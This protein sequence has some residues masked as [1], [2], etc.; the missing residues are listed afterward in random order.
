M[1]L[2]KAEQ[3]ELDALNKELGPPKTK[4]T[5]VGGLTP[6]EQAE[7]DALNKEL[8]PPKHQ[9]K[10]LDTELPFSTS[11]RGLIKSGASALPIAGAMLGGVVGT[12]LGPLGTVGGAGLGA[13]G[14]KSLQTTIEQGLLGEKKTR[15]QVYLDPLKEGAYGAAGEG[16]GQALGAG[17]KMVGQ[18]KPAKYA[19]KKVGDA[20]ARTGEA[21]TGISKKEI[22]T[23]A[24]NA[25]EIVDLYKSNDGDVQEAADAM[26][27]GWQE[28]IQ[29]TRKG[30]N[31]QISQALEKRVDEF[32]DVTDVVDELEKAKA[33]MN[34]KLRSGEIA[35]VD[36][37]IS[38]IQE[39]SG[40]GEALEVSLKDA[41]DLKEYLQEIAK[42]SYQKGGQIFQ[43]GD[44]A[45]KAAK[46]GAAMARKAVNKAAPEIAKANNAL[47]NLHNIE[48]KVNK[49]ILA[50]GKTV[51]PV[52]AIGSG[53]NQQNIKMARMLDEATGAGIISDSEKLAAMR[54]FGSPQILPVDTTGKSV[55]RMAMGTLLGSQV[56]GPIG[57][58]MGG[59]LSSPLTLKYGIQGGRAIGDIGKG[60]LVDNPQLIGQ[61]LMQN[62]KRKI[63][64][65]LMNE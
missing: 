52:M 23:F 51:A 8:G 53:A 29:N 20:L 24:K 2:S 1:P 35:E 41:H 57:A 32:V 38:K 4:M 27:R 11:P 21:L 43:T 50:E 37:L 45:Q 16:A 59:A 17:L 30:L 42:G 31:S 55:G 64:R 56:G 12:A 7:L 44:K 22:K 60:I 36:D 65:G 54:T 25:D 14:G 48:N 19:A 62:E 5:K 15:K 58:A 3:A 49:N 34:P 26:R 46:A 39:M 18:S 10:W 47:A 63:K 40:G 6:E 33:L 9:K 61:A 28:R 13:V